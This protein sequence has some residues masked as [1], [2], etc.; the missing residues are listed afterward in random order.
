MHLCNE[1]Y[2]DYACR[3]D[4]ISVCLYS[5]SMSGNS[6]NKMSASLPLSA[7]SIGP[8]PSILAGAL[9]HKMSV[10]VYT[11]HLIKI[12]ISTKPQSPWDHS[13]YNTHINKAS[14]TE[15]PLQVSPSAHTPVVFVG[16]G[17]LP[18]ERCKC[19]TLLLT[20]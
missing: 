3:Q 19:I 18:A 14:A 10:V 12:S 2:Q 7:S 8:N 17:N 20:V 1:E 4:R 13:D 6:P 5:E 9:L 11:V 15:I 16:S